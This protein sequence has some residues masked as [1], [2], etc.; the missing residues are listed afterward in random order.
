MKRLWPIATLAASG[1]LLAAAAWLCARS[2]LVVDV[3]SSGWEALTAVGTVGATL[4]AL[5]LALDAWRQRKDAVARLVSAWVT[6]EYTPRLDESAY[7][8]IVTLHVANEGDQPVFDAQVSVLIGAQGIR[9]GPLAAPSPIAV[10]PPRRALTFDL[11]VA[12]LAHDDTYYPRAEV[13]FLDPRRRRWVRDG[14][15]VLRRVSKSPRW[16]KLTGSEHEQQLGNQT[17]NNPMIVARAFLAGLRDGDAP[18]VKAFDALL[19]PEAPGWRS[20]DWTEVRNLVDGYQPTSMIDYPATHI[21]RV[22]LS[23]DA[24]LEGKVVSGY[25]EMQLR[26]WQF[27]TLTYVPKRGWRIFGVG[28]SVPPEAILFPDGTFPHDG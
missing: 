14:N 6:E 24:S 27:L 19:A 25:G 20:V 2:G 1:A 17:P 28:G 15:G 12:L 26:D 3:D 16:E 5:A 10:V 13:S 11:S 8:R 22:K 23:G 7:Q 21:A 4:V 18:D 9:L